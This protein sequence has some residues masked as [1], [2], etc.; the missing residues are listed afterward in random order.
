MHFRPRLLCGEIVY[1]F[2]LGGIVRGVW[3]SIVSVWTKES[4]IHV[5]GSPHACLRYPG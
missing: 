4:T 1:V 5:V 2:R 3:G